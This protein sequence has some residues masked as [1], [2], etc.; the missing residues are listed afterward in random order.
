VSATTANPEAAWKW[1]RFLT[2]SD[3]TVATRLASSWDLPPVSDTS[4]LK[5][6]LDV[7]PPAN[8]QAVFDSLDAI[9]LPPVIASQQEMQDA[10][11]KELASAAAGR[12]SV[13]QALDDAVVA[14]NKLLG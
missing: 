4:K 1:V 8:R 10:V 12:K 13:Q 3:T 6:Y 2:S 9:A 14:V 11:T 5:P 7:T